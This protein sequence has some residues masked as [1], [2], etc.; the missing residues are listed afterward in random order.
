MSTKI[1]KLK[2]HAEPFKAVINGEKT[3][4]IRKNDRDFQR[5]DILKLMEYKGDYTGKSWSVWVSYIL[6]GPNYGV[7][8]G[9]CIMSIT[10]IL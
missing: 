9:Y 2:T 3:F 6:H 5:G 4:E 8:E 1:H 10:P 7:P